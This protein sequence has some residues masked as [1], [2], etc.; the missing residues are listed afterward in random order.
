M[1]LNTLALLQIA[2]TKGQDFLIEGLHK[3]GYTD[4]RPVHGK[5]F[6]FIDRENGSQ[7]VELARKGQVT[8]Q[9]MSQLISQ[10]E[11]SGYIIKKDHH[12]DKRSWL[13]KLTAKGKRSVKV[14]DAVI[15][16]LENKYIKLLTHGN[17]ETLR[18]ILTKV[19]FEN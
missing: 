6:A 14:A 8:K 4:I 7:L 17:H 15:Q 5:V 13:V 3:S 12:S 10:L 18:E 1:N 16:E 2:F 11:E 9:F 19:C